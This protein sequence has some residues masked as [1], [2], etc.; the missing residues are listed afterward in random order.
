MVILRG[1]WFI[2]FP[3]MRSTERS[4]SRS[5][6]AMNLSGQDNTGNKIDRS[7]EPKVEKNIKW[8]LGLGFMPWAHVDIWI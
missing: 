4:Y 3:K 2:P 1:K 8:C 5:V 7:F 6:P